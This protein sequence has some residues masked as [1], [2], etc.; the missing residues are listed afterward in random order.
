MANRPKGKRRAA[1]P[2]QSAPLRR[3]GVEG[4]EWT[5]EEL[6]DFLKVKPGTIASWISRGVEVPP[7][8]R[9]GSITRWNESTVREWL[10][11][12]EQTRRERN[13]EP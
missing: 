12:R 13:F 11:Q 2:S 7:F 1:G 10:R 3:P 6:A 8:V 9:I 4:A 5:L